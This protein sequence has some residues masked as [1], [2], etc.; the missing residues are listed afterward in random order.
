MPKKRDSRLNEKG[1]SAKKKGIEN[2]EAW[3]AADWRY[4]GMLAQDIMP[5][6]WSPLT[7]QERID[8]LKEI[9]SDCPEYY[10]A[11]LECGYRSIKDGKDEAAREFID[12]GLQSLKRH[13]TKEDLLD[14]YYQ[15]CE[16]LEEHLRFEMAI[17]YYNQLLEIATDKAEVH[18]FISCCYV[19]LGDLDK[20]V[21]SQRRALK[22]SPTNHR[23][24]CNMGW[25]ELI[26]GNLDA[27]GSALERSLKLDQTDEVAVNNYQIY[28]LMRDNNHLKDWEAFL[29]RDT[30]HEKL[31]GLEDDDKE[32]EREVRHYNRDRIEA[33]KFDLIRNPHYTQTRKYDILFT[34]NYIMKFIWDLHTSAFFFYDDISTVSEY[35]GP[36]MH[37]FILKT[38][39]I[40]EEIL[41]DVYA[42]ILEFY[43]FLTRRKVVSGYKRL[44]NRMK[45][46]KPE[47]IE[48]MLR[49][50]EIRHNDEYSEEEKDEIREE[51]FGD[52]YFFPFL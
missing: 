3:Q 46:L 36:I 50:N 22:L 45:K 39:D 29:L 28:E 13:F 5:L 37:S 43:K 16:I 31:K 49:Y 11:L 8:F 1:E 32:Y 4:T 18:D 2:T 51:L 25:I 26:R 7:G 34:L 41:N 27:A 44:E 9:L 38:S 10:P 52:S 35:F 40:D 12:K 33:F 23:F 30:D 17:E 24:H 20:A 47:L 42:A 21:A 19:Y 15:V 14:T 6:L 48:K